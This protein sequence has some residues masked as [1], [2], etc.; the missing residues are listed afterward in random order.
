MPCDKNNVPSAAAQR[1][2][3][4]VCLLD[5]S[6]A[7][8]SFNRAAEFFACSDTDT[9]NARAVF[10]HISY[11]RRMYVWFAPSIGSAEITVLLKCG[12][13]RQSNQPVRLKVRNESG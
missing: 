5:N 2:H 7:T 8:V 10:Q 11:Q 9:A 13:F 6:A 1:G 4:A 12:Y 3:V